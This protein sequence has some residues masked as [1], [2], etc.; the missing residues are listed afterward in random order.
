MKKIKKAVFPIAGFGTRFF[1]ITK[2]FPKEMLPLIDKPLLQYTVEEALQSGI[3]EFIFI[4]RKEKNSIQD[5]FQHFPRLLSP[6]QIH[7][8]YQEKPLGLGQAVYC[9]RRLI[10]NEFFAVLLPDELILA[11]IPCLQQLINVYEQIQTNIIAIHPVAQHEVSQYGIIEGEKIPST[12]TLKLKG[13]MEKP[14]PERA[15]SSL[16]IAGR[17]LLSSRVFSYLEKQMP[18]TGGEIQLT[19]SLHSLL[20]DEDFYGLEFEGQRFDCGSKKG[21]FSASLKLALE[22]HEIKVEIEKVLKREGYTKVTAPRHEV[23]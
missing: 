16:A 12:S 9:A 17:Y 18:G 10:N 23:L 8:V 5:Y 6:R 21:Y 15:P 20:K 1:P 22:R 13:M 11:K 7:Y 3:E 19:D 4:T 2:T 14:S